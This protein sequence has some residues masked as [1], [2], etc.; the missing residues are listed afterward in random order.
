MKFNPGRQNDPFKYKGYDAFIRRYEGN[1]F[2]SVDAIEIR[3]VHRASVRSD[4][5]IIRFIIT[6]R[7]SLFHCLHR[8]VRALKNAEINPPPRNKNDG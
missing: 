3:L 1:E 4:D 6:N 5:M 7:K 2:M 8:A